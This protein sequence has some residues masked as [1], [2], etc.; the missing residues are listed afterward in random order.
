MSRK[1]PIQIQ[2]K[3]MQDP[4]PGEEL[5]PLILLGYIIPFIPT[6][7]G[8]FLFDIIN[9]YKVCFPSFS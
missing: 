4:E 1:E 5:G 8:F 6:T 2:Q 7:L 3:Q 9:K